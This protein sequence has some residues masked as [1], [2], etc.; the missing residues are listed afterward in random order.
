MQNV[1]TDQTST[2]LELMPS[3]LSLLT[4]TFCGQIDAEI[5]EKGRVVSGTVSCQYFTIC[6]RTWSVSVGPKHRLKL[7][8]GAAEHNTSEWTQLL[9]AV[10]SSA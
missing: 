6:S 3:Y 7:L 8:A 4:R 2:L 10:T 5:A 9:D 1:I